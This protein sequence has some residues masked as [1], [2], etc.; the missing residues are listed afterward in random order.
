MS[1]KR[2]LNALLKRSVEP[3]LVELGFERS[4]RIFSAQRSD[5]T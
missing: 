5:V 4:G 2:R 3:R 1:M